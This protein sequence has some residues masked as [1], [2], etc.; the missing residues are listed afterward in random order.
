MLLDAPRIDLARMAAPPRWTLPRLRIDQ[1]MMTCLKYILPLSCVL[2]LGV[3][4]W[5]RVVPEPV[6]VYFR[7]VMMVVCVALLAWLIVKWISFTQAPPSTAMPGMWR[8]AGLP[9]YQGAKP[10]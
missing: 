2:L 10:Q 1:V 9:G 3:T 5:Y 7:Y 4:L 8:T 6:V